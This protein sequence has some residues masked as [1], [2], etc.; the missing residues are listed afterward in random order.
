[1]L[2]RR[3]EGFGAGCAISTYSKPSR[4]PMPALSRG[5]SQA[6]VGN[7]PLS[8]KA[9]LDG[10]SKVCAQPSV[11]PHPLRRTASESVCKGNTKCHLLVW[12][13]LFLRQVTILR[14]F[15]IKRFKPTI[16]NGKILREH[17]MK[18]RSKWCK[19]LNIKSLLPVPSSEATAHRFL[20]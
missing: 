15:L 6:Q 18:K 20:G 11:E 3:S 4:E 16:F 5:P 19:T 1:M 12:F 8:P 17:K 14:V 9:V 13:C 10:K 2:R 7:H